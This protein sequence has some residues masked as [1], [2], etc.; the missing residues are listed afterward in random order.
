MMDN[1][2]PSLQ[3]RLEAAALN[4]L[5]KTFRM[6]N[7]DKASA[8]GGFLARAIGPYLS[9]HKIAGYNLSMIFPEMPYEEKQRILSGMWD[10]LGRT[11]AELPFIPSEKLYERLTIHGTENIHTDYPCIFFSGHLGNWELTY[12]IAQRNGIKTTLIY[13]KANNPIVED[14]IRSIRATQANNLIVKGP[15]GSFKLM[16]AIKNKESLALLIDQK[17]NDGIPVPFFGRL[18]M[19]APAL[20]EFA[21]R[22]NL[23]IVPARIVRKKGAHFEAFIY[24]QLQYVKS[25][26]DERDKLTI[27]T[28]VNE[29]MEGWIREHPEQWFWVHRRWPKDS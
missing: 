28:K 18:A 24:P 6:L 21:L 5:F 7:L 1:N 23:P 19:T 16:R 20:A 27:M 26:D 25:G 3:H 11:A 4:S 17:M 15:K 22:F 12:P 29:I 2:T 10:N 9:A 8:I 13:R 14:M